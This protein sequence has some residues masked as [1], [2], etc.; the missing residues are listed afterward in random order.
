MENRFLAIFTLKSDKPAVYTIKISLKV[1]VSTYN[2]INIHII[3]TIYYEDLHLKE[4]WQ[5][6]VYS[7]RM[8]QTGFLTTLIPPNS[9]QIQPTMSATKSQITRKSSKAIIRK[10]HGYWVMLITIAAL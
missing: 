5:P 9:A 7:K 2:F 4:D 1:Q 6:I 3:I 10:V 8:Q